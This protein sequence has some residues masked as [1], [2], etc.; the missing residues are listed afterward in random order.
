VCSYAL[1]TL[2]H[3]FVSRFQVDYV[4]TENY[5]NRKRWVVS[6]RSRLQNIPAHLAWIFRH[7]DHTRS[8]QYCKKKDLFQLLIHLYMA[9]TVSVNVSGEWRLNSKASF[10]CLGATDSRLLSRAHHTTTCWSTSFW[11]WMS[12]LFRQRLLLVHQLLRAGEVCT[13]P[14]SNANNLVQ[15]I[16]LHLATVRSLIQ[17]LA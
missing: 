12:V 14:F 5:D 11:L 9:V 7:G 16:A 4:I 8:K 2:T 3:A 1:K 10:C 15:T 17:L 6:S 13:V